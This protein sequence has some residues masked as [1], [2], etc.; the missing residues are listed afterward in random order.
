V[1]VL[2]FKKGRDFTIIPNEMIRSTALTF[3]AKGFLTLALSMAPEWRPTLENLHKFSKEGIKASRA[4]LHELLEA[5]YIVRYR[6]RSEDNKRFGD[7]VYIVGHEPFT[8]EELLA[9]FGPEAA[10]AWKRPPKQLWGK[11]GDGT[12]AE[13]GREDPQSQ[14]SR[15]DMASGKAGKP[16]SSCTPSRYVPK[17]HVTGRQDIEEK[18]GIE[19]K[20]DRRKDPQRPQLPSVVGGSPEPSPK[21][22]DLP[23]NPAEDFKPMTPEEAVLIRPEDISKAVARVRGMTGEAGPVWKKMLLLMEEVPVARLVNTCILDPVEY[24]AEIG[25]LWKR[26]RNGSAVALSPKKLCMCA[27][28][29]SAYPELRFADNLAELEAEL[30]DPSSARMDIVRRSYDELVDKYAP[31]YWE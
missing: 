5:G 20:G 25:N 22:E 2:K 27:L 9:D 21:A 6:P 7:W 1:P 30:G 24:A 16:C 11:A 13:P 17:G 3:K 28:V 14:E 26:W 15:T 19:D 8:R 10:D 23:S 31:G 18:G 12:S 4:A 29:Y